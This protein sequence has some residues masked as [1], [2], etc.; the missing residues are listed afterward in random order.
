[1]YTNDALSLILL[2]PITARL[3]PIAAPFPALSILTIPLDK[4]QM[5]S[6]ETIIIFYQSKT[7]LFEKRSFFGKKLL[8]ERKTHLGKKIFLFFLNKKLEKNFFTS[9]AKSL[10]HK[11]PAHKRRLQVN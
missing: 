4:C 1:M 8:F 7:F 9:G 2:Q 3:F 11:R 10:A 6:F 5:K